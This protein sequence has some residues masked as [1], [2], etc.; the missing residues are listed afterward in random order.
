MKKITF[1]ILIL[2]LVFFIA[3]HKDSGPIIMAPPP[4]Q[5]QPISYSGEIQ[6]I[7]DAYCVSCHDDAHFALN[8]QPCCSW[9]QL[10]SGGL[11]APYVNTLNPALSSLHMRVIGTELPAMPPGGPE[12][13]Q[14]EK[15]KIYRWIEEGALN[16]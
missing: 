11:N 13:L 15:D 6:S 2:S 1:C 4:V 14:S 8:L 5:I 9:D 16:N 10:W 7:F 3:C 12:L